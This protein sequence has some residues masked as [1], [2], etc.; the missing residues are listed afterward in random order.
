MAS[1]IELELGKKPKRRKIGSVGREDV[2]QLEESV[3]CLD[4]FRSIPAGSIIFMQP[5]TAGHRIPVCA[6]FSG[7]DPAKIKLTGKVHRCEECSCPAFAIGEE[8]SRA[9][10]AKKVREWGKERTN[11]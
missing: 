5:V 4:C 3:G 11:E 10:Y 2:F 7:V 8:K 9:P 6:Y 1:E